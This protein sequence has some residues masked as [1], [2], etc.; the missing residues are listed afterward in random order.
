MYWKKRVTGVLLTSALLLSMLTPSIALQMDAS[1]V[2]NKNEPAQQPSPILDIE[3]EQPEVTEET[4][5]TRPEE[6]TAE[7]PTVEPPIVEAPA[8]EDAITEQPT[9]EIPAE[10]VPTVRDSI[11]EQPVEQITPIPQEKNIMQPVALRT[12]HFAYMNGYTDGTFGPNKHLTWA[13]VSFILYSLLADQSMGTYPYQYTD[14]RPEVWYYEAVSVLAS[15]GILRCDGGKLNP[16]Q[17]ISRADFVTVVVQ[18]TGIDETATCE[19]TDVSPTSSYYLPIATAVKQGWISGFGDNTFR[20]NELLTRAQTAT[21]FNLVLGR[22]IDQRVLNSATDLR[23]FP[24]VSKTAWYYAAVMEA[25]IDHVGVNNGDGTETWKSYTHS[26]VITLK[27]SGTST[28]QLVYEGLKPIVPKKD[29]SGKIITHWM[30][31]DGTVANPVKTPVH[32]PA[33]YTAWYAPSLITAHKQYVSGYDRKTFGPNQALN[34]AQAATLLYGLLADQQKGT[35]AS[36]FTDVKSSAWYYD[37]V[38]V[39]ASKGLLTAGGAFR[40]NDVMTREEFVEMVTRLVP[41][42]STNITFSDVSADH[43]YY[44][45]IATALANGW[46]TGFGDGTFQPKGTLTRAQAVVVF[47]KIMG[48]TGDPTTEQQM[49]SRYTFTDVAKIAWYYQNVMEA[50]TT[51]TYKKTSAGV[52]QWSEYTHNYT[53]T[54]SWES[55]TSVVAASKITNSIT[56]TYG[57]DFTHKYNVDYADGLKEWYINSKGYSSSTKYLVW[58]SR[59]NQK[60]YVFTGSK[61]NWKISKTFICGTGKLSTPTPVGVTYITY[62]QE[63]WYTSNYM[64]KPV[65]RFYPNTGYAFHSRLYYPNGKGLKDPSIGWPVSE[66]CVRMLDTDIIYLYKNIPNNSTVVIY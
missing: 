59:Q 17:E 33:V 2:I 1:D 7:A 16:N 10:E 20:P 24:D 53:E 58:V 8:E 56:S 27:Y 39:L 4:T 65:V 60:V 21:V 47:N 22:K 31:A 45:A 50:A 34:R 38:T 46:I 12:D 15:R 32:S 13:Q 36:T 51:H 26:Y 62:R 41:Y 23:S 44:D 28:T 30:A 48:R 5:I 63:G 54:V 18:V 37:K 64:C 35:Y 3:T 6:P 9:V 52:E 40:P 29:K 57:G 14:V 61:G 66:G 42:T 43:P 11:P 49:D 55:S 19:F 25:T